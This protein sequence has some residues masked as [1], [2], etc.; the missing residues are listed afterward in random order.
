MKKMK[1]LISVI[2]PVY[3]VEQYLNKCVDSIINQTYKNLEI[4]LVDDGSPD[5]CGEICDEYAE[6]DDRVKVIHKENGGQGSARNMGLDICKG[7]YI[8]FVD[9]DDWID[10]DMYE[11]MMSD[12]LEYAADLSMCNFWIVNGEKIS[13]EDGCEDVIVMNNKQLMEFY[14]SDSRMNTS[15]CNKLYKKD[16]W[17]GLRYPENVF[18]EDELIL[19]KVLLKA[20]KTVHTG[21]P[22]YFYYIRTGSSEHSGF[23]PKY[24][25][26]C[27]SI[28]RQAEEVLRIYPDLKDVLNDVRLWTRVKIASDMIFQQKVNMYKDIY[29]DIKRFIKENRFCGEEHKQIR[30]Y[31]ICFGTNYVYVNKMKSFVKKFLAVRH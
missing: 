6:K 27:E 19:Y 8:A 21:L 16:L 20:D 10:L 12:L 14:Y 18:R 25:I 29:K 22:K 28:D 17:E 1:P 13:A 2:V 9:S 26:S 5:R 11:C 24:L 31:I 15:P 30:R 7:E 4:I 23:S 3:N